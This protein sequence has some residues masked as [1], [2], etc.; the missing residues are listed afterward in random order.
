MQQHHLKVSGIMELVMVLVT[1][2][3]FTSETVAF[4]F[5]EYFDGSSAN[6]QS[7]SASQEKRSWLPS[8]EYFAADT[9]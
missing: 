1:L 6:S 8:R 2:L 5:P 3:A 9:C 7:R 4:M